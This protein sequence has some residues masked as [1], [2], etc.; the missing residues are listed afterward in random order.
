MPPQNRTTFTMPLLSRA[1][2]NLGNR[3]DEFPAP[4]ADVGKLIDDLVLQIPGQDQDVVRSRLLNSLGR[5]DRDMG[6]RQKF[7]VLVWVA[8]NGVVDKVRTNPAVIQ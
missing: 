4:V 1:H 3:N 2:L 7:V 5:E 6:S 8:I